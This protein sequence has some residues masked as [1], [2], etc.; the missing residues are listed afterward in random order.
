MTNRL[1]FTFGWAVV[2][3]TQGSVWWGNGVEYQ[4]AIFRTKREAKTFLARH[5]IDEPHEIRRVHIQES[6]TRK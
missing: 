6:R 3:D 5:G 4:A 2:G 1:L